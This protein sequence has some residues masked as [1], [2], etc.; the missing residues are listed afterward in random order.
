MANLH[1]FSESSAHGG[2]SLPKDQYCLF[3]DEQLGSLPILP[4]RNLVLDSKV[5][6]HSQ[7][8]LFCTGSVTIVS[9]AHGHRWN[10][11]ANTEGSWFVLPWRCP[12]MQSPG[13]VLPVVWVLLRP[14]SDKSDT[15]PSRQLGQFKPSPASM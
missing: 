2:K 8:V 12:K 1:V 7:K 5:G 11:T 4:N 14:S 6:R 3:S 10:W 9:A 15:R 13:L